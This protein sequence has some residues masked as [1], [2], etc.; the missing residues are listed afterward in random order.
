MNVYGDERILAGDGLHG[1][2]IADQRM[3]ALDEE[4][5][6][7]I[8]TFLHPIT[9]V[10]LGCGAG[11]QVAR[12]VEAGAQ[13]LGI[14]IFNQEEVIARKT[15][16]RATFLCRDLLDIPKMTLPMTPWNL[17]IS[18]R[19]IHYFTYQQAHSIL[20]GVYDNMEGKL[21]ISASGMKSELSFGYPHAHLPVQDRYAFLEDNMAN[22][23]GIM[24]RVCLYHEEELAELLQEIGFIVEKASH[25]TFGNCKVVAR[26]P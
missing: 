1:V 24:S 10:D 5:I 15:N 22:R 3:D 4:A 16:N 17:V 2:D 25:S 13:V 8:K 26:H 19:T 6:Q 21:F 9:A 12:M 11:G 20:K 14:D 7:Y 23:H 18:Q